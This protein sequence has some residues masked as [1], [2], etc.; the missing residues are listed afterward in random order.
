[1]LISQVKNLPEH[2]HDLRGDS[3]D[4]HYYI[5]RDVAGTPND[6]EAIIFDAPTGVGAGQALP[7]VVVIET[8]QA[9]GQAMNVMNPI[10][11]T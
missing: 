1:M 2:K 5:T 11:D 8:Q 9:L 7:I 6:N 4:G 10:H 3:G